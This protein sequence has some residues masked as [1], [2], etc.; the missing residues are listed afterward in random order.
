MMSVLN[1]LCVRCAKAVQSLSAARR[2]IEG[3]VYGRG[4]EEG[5]DYDQDDSGG[6]SS[7]SSSNLLQRRGASGSGGSSGKELNAG[8]TRVISD[9]ER[10]GVKPGER[11]VRAVNMIDG[12]ANLTGRFLRSYPLARLGFVL[13]LLVLHVWVLFVLVLHMETLQMQMD[14]EEQRQ[15][16]LN[17]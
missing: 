17:P 3:G 7:S 8:P 9:L 2:D 14:A 6:S 11:V 13:Y 16:L 4:D 12:W 1:V 10:I 5:G 15:Q